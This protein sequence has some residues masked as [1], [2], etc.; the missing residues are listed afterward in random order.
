MKKIL[1]VLLITSLACLPASA[2]FVPG[3]TLGAAA[4]NAALAAPTILGG[5]INGAPIGVTNPQSGRFTTL[6]APQFVSTATPGTAPFVVGSNTL[7][8]NLNASQLL[9]NTWAAP[10]NIGGTTPGNGTFVNTTLT[11]V[12]AWNRDLGSMPSG[13]GNTTATMATNITGTVSGSG[14][15]ATAAESKVFTISGTDYNTIY[16]YRLFLGHLGTGTL[17]ESIGFYL[18]TLSENTAT[19][20]DAAGYHSSYTMSGT[21]KI[22]NFDQFRANGGNNSPGTVIT[23]LIGFHAKDMLIGGI[24]SNAVNLIGFQ[25]DDQT[26]ATS[27]NIGF[28]SSLLSGANRYNAYF[29]GTAENLFTG[30]FRTGTVGT[31]PTCTSNCGTSPSIIG[32]D[33]AMRVTMGATGAPASGFVITFTTAWASSPS[34]VAQMAKSGMVIGKMPIVASPTTTTLTITTNGTAPANSDIYA[35]HCLGVS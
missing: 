17:D 25:A 5:S 9:G 19:I 7:V 11:G 26:G 15:G 18:Q 35:V 3:Q 34:C 6:T 32:N 23:N 16:G 8:P 14:F 22:T 30:R 21:G 31:P 13:G 12:G 4:L 2:Q 1:A 27:L 28:R 20:T 29:D 24:S 33:T 10:G